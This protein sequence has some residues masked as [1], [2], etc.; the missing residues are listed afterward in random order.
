MI[1]KRVLLLLIVVATGLIACKNMQTGTSLETISP[2]NIS[3]Y[4]TI[5]KIVSNNCI[6]CHTGKYPQA[7]LNL[8]NYENLVDAVKNKN[9]LHRINDPQ[10]PMPTSGLMSKKERL[11]FE[12]WKENNFALTTDSSTTSAEVQ[13]YSFEPPVL[14]AINI[15]EKGFDFLE[16]IQGHWVG[17]IFLLGNNIPWFAFDFRAINTSQV[18]AIFEGGSMGNLFNTFFVAEYKGVKTIMLRNGGI[19]GG[20]YRTSYFVLTKAENNEYF[21]EDA[22]G[23]KQVMWVKISFQKDKM[24]MLTYTSKLGVKKAT[25]HMEFNGKKLHS[26]LAQKA[27]QQFGFPTKKVTYRFPNGMPLPNW[28]EEY[29]VVTSGSYITNDDKTDYLTLGKRAKDPIQITDIKNIAELKLLLQRNDLSKDKNITVY[30][31]R[32]PLTN[33]SGKLKTE[34]GYISQDAMNQVV[35]FSEIDKKDN[36]FTFLYLHTGKYYI[37]CIV[38]NNKDMTPNKGDFYSISKEINLTEKPITLYAE[39]IVNTIN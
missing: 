21:F 28:G 13:K 33:K 39:E 25:R 17:N 35:L 1:S 24:K 3:Y 23:G 14:K 30:L 38:D 20:I 18:H 11:A 7:G 6:T 19:L 29:P 12:R 36:Q 34:Y 31:S 10:N 2:E 32:E 37:T 26:D 22:Y 15:E 8:K 27:S 4:N 5:K 16:K 9:L